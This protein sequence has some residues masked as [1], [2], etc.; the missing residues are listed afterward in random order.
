MSQRLRPRRPEREPQAAYRRR[1]G[2]GACARRSAGRPRA[3][4][5][6]RGPAGPARSGWSRRC[7]GGLG[8]FEAIFGG[9]FH[10]VRAGPL[11]VSSMG[12]AVMDLPANYGEYP[13]HDQEHDHQ[14]EV[15]TALSGRATIRAS[16]SRSTRSSP[17]CGSASGRRR[18]AR[19]SPARG[20]GAGACDRRL[21]RG[22]RTSLRSSPRR[23]TG[24]L[25][26]S[27]RCK[28]AAARAGR[29]G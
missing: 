18:S 21:A 25:G 22:A 1:G 12:I 16:G 23:R 11:G 20:A 13:E 5:L 15:Y 14:E 17:G 9:G 27:T 2:D 8:E 3:G 10:R 6:Q 29:P 19:S 24:P 26:A 28:R 7:P 4:H